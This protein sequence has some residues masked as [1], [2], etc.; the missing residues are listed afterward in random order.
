MTAMGDT[1]A[2]DG[3]TPVRAAAWPDAPQRAAASDGR[4]LEAVEAAIATILNLPATAVIAYAAADEAVRAALGRPAEQPEGDGARDE[5]RDE[6]VLPSISTSR[7]TP[8]L[9]QAARAGGWRV[10]PGEVEPDSATLALRGLTRALGPQTGMAV[11]AHAFGHPAAMTELMRVAREHGVT[12]VED[13]TGAL[14]ATYRHEPVGRLGH[15]GLMTTSAGD[16]VTH[17]A[18]VIA[19][20][21]A[22]AASLRAARHGALA[23]E[24]ARIALAD[25]RALPDEIEQRRQL[26]WELTFGLHGMRGVAPM[27]HG[28]WIQHAY[29]S[30]V[31]RLRTAVWRRPIA[32]TVEA[33][34]AEGIPATEATGTLL[35]RDPAIVQ[36]LPDD[37]RLHDDV[38]VAASRLPSELI[39]VPLHSGLTSR[40]MAD[41]AAA[42][43]KLEAHS[44]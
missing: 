38:F 6:I 42:L 2:I 31:V 10:V 43:R 35:H 25:V 29:A 33:L 19:P 27:A 32:E 16:P 21:P 41:V 39:A 22:D 3:G 15:R 8:Q 23:D 44:S 12:L 1:L 24:D 36:A 11:V 28:R 17:G 18:Y 20:D 40:D 37:P 26:A 7:G 9:A 5:M 13:V 14:G 34:R 4:P 30:Y